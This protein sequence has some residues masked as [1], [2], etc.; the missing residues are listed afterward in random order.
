MIS[1]EILKEIRVNTVLP[2]HEGMFTNL[3]SRIDELISY[4]GHLKNDVLKTISPESMTAYEIT[5]RINWFNSQTNWKA[6][7]PVV[8]A[9]LVTKCLSYLKA[10]ETEG[11]AHQKVDKTGLRLYNA[12]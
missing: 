9:G 2:G 6:L 10:L 5:S 12:T 3:G 1:L 11:K 4:H 7:A 8:Q